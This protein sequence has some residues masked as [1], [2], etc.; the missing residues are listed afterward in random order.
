MMKQQP[1]ATGSRLSSICR[2]LIALGLVKVVILVALAAGYPLPELFFDIKSS[3]DIFSEEQVSTKPTSKEGTHLSV[4][5]QVADNDAVE[6]PASKGTDQ[7]LQEATTKIAPA[8]DPQGSAAVRAALALSGGTP[9]TLLNSTT[10]AT[11]SIQEVAVHQPSAVPAKENTSWWNKM[12]ELKALPFPRL[13]LDQAA[14]AATLDA[15]PPP[16]IPAVPNSLQGSPFVEPGQST[17]TSQVLPAGTA[18]P[19][20]GAGGQNALVPTTNIPAPAVASALSAEDPGQKAQE[21]ARRE[22]E[23]LVLKRQMEQ[24][25]QELH[26][27]ERKVQGMLDEAKDL[28]KEKV[29]GL[30][31]M[32]MNMKP[33]QAAKAMET[34]DES[35]AVKILSSM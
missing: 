19:Q 25:L 29:T 22:Q 3:N 13:G 5:A 17:G 11:P 14:H 24:R 9:D 26:N 34:L 8:E 23:M 30:T 4:S 31:S 7:L 18:G 10:E 21:L 35:I 32:Y 6:K 28:E 20:A 1:S 27:A 33:K 2:A 15:P 12:L 16:A